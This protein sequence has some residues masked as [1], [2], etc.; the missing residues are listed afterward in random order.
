MASMEA[1]PMRKSHDLR[2]LGTSLVGFVK[3]I[4]NCQISA[5]PFPYVCRYPSLP[6]NTP[7]RGLG[8][9]D[10]SRIVINIQSASAW[11]AMRDTMSLG[12]VQRDGIQN[13]ATP[14]HSASL[15]PVETVA[16]RQRAFIAWPDCVIIASTER[17][18]R[19]CLAEKIWYRCWM[20]DATRDPLP[21]ITS[22]QPTAPSPNT[23]P[24]PTPTHQLQR[25]AAYLMIGHHCRFDRYFTLCHI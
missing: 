2:D 10:G 20:G 18:G 15:S 21:I 5:A 16:G 11:W 9:A 12:A 8:L 23:Y 3:S 14:R 13:H 17:T 22:Y 19:T 24:E 4:H 1:E 25:N 7:P 6:N